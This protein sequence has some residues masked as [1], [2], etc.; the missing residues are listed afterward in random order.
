MLKSF[1]NYSLL[2]EID[3]NLL[4]TPSQAQPQGGGDPFMKELTRIEQ[5]L[6]AMIETQFKN[7]EQ[8]LTGHVQSQM[9]TNRP[10]TSK[11]RNWWRKTWNPTAPHDEAFNPSL[12]ALDLPDNIKLELP[13][14]VSLQEEKVMAELLAIL[15]EG[16]IQDTTARVS[17]ELQRLKHELISNVVQ[18]FRSITQ[19][20]QAVAQQGGQQP[21]PQQAAPTPQQN[22]PQ[23]PAQPFDWKGKL[24]NWQDSQPKPAD[25]QAPPEDEQ[26]DQPTDEPDP[27]TGQADDQ[28]TPD[29]AP[30]ADVPPSTVVPG[31]KP[32]GRR[33]KGDGVLQ[34]PNIGGEEPAAPPEEPDAQGE[35]PTA[36]PEEPQAAP[37]PPPDEETP[38]GGIGE[39]TAPPEAPKA[40]KLG[41]G[42]KPSLG[43]KPSLG[44]PSAALGGTGPNGEITSDDVHR[45]FRHKRGVMPANMVSSTPQ[46]P[47]NPNS[48]GDVE[49]E[50]V[51]VQQ[52][53]RKMMLDL[54]P[55]TEKLYK[56]MG[57]DQEAKK[58]I[59]DFLSVLSRSPNTTKYLNYIKGF[60]IP[61]IVNWSMAFPPNQQA[62]IAH[63]LPF[64]DDG[65]SEADPSVTKSFWDRVDKDSFYKAVEKTLGSKYKP[66]YALMAKY[67]E[68]N[69]KDRVK[70]L[71][72]LIKGPYRSVGQ[73]QTPEG[74]F[75]ER[76]EKYRQL[77]GN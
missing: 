21:A 62:D 31:R 61:Q 14:F 39:P 24:K 67:V 41:L 58:N 74:T 10:L 70:T 54:W 22:K 3:F 51:N 52:K 13:S 65:A 44:N 6:L 38:G 77:L 27:A 60:P 5:S 16:P 4:N 55:G 59:Y 12:M 35:D 50:H 43:G 25:D 71:C 20:Y 11:L 49:P 63:R 57:R 42:R 7:L 1:N 73:I 53:D 47:F 75:A 46:P 26:P 69:L 64:L 56:S 37:E 45:V 30:A 17:V 19:G 68:S 48:A 33:K 28:G 23:A 34:G 15:N 9:R 8:I 72:E 66:D 40:P 29:A 18:A 32:R 2:S 36:P 76:L